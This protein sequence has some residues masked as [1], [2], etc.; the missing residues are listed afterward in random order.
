[1]GI[2]GE[3]RWGG[4]MLT[5]DVIQIA[6]RLISLSLSSTQ[7]NLLLHWYS[8]W[9][10]ALNILRWMTRAERLLWGYMVSLLEIRKETT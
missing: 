2:T 1:M 9:E 10:I 5:E 6:F 4:P 3:G 7:A 8:L